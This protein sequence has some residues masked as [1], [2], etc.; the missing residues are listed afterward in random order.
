[1]PP[2]P[3]HEPAEEPCPDIVERAQAGD[4][5]AYTWLFQQHVGS[6]YKYLV[7][8]TGNEEDAADLTQQTF[9]QAW[10]RLPTLHTPTLFQTW[11]FMIARNLAYDQ[12]RLHRRSPAM[13]SLETLD[14]SDV[15]SHHPG[16]EA[17]VIAMELIKQVFAALTPKL[18][19]C[20]LLQE[21]GFAHAEIAALVGI[22][23]ASVSTYLSLARKQFV[24]VYLQIKQELEVPEKGGQSEDGAHRNSLR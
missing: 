7:Y 1:M 10:L 5:D 9:L 24:Q 19:D 14:P 20:L 8:L 2:P 12:G 13:Q 18:R 22:S 17:S 4:R 23:R 15:I 21:M 16:L 3:G 11:L 6:I